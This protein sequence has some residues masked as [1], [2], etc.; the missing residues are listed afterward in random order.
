[1]PMLCL[2]IDNGPGSVPDSRGNRCFVVVASSWCCVRADEDL[3]RVLS[4]P[5][6]SFHLCSVSSSRL[7]PRQRT[8]V[9]SFLAEHCVAL[10]LAWACVCCQGGGRRL[11]SPYG[12]WPGAVVTGEG[13]RLFGSWL[14]V[15][16][17]GTVCC[18]VSTATGIFK[19]C[20]DRQ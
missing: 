16:Q 11:Q 14:P 3:R 5:C 10:V 18:G 7:G 9:L 13:Q 12:V 17:M 19:L 6:C 4:V 15:V 20:E 1:M 2:T 8:K